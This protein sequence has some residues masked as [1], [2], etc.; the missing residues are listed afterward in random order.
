MKSEK[1]GTVPAATCPDSSLQR[2]KEGEVRGGGGGRWRW[3]GRG[4]MFWSVFHFSF[5]V[6]LNLMEDGTRRRV[7]G[8]FL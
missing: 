6:W 7:A 4:V 2:Q 8:A 5:N 3:K 1:G